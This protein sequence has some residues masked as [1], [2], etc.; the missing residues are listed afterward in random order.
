MRRINRHIM[1]VWSSF[2]TWIRLFFFSRFGPNQQ[3]SKYDNT[4]NYEWNIK[5]SVSPDAQIIY[6]LSSNAITSICS[7]ECVCVCFCWWY[8][9]RRI[10]FNVAYIISS[11]FF[12]FFILQ[13]N[14]IKIMSCS[15]ARLL[16][17]HHSST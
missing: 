3:V 15:V 9:Y 7:I 16:F 5:I 13:L 8:E 2:D 1:R 4:I 10:S 12:L 14:N 11:V 6:I 17:L